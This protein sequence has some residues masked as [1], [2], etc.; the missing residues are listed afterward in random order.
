MPFS[1]L[2]YPLK[3]I[4]QNKLSIK[5]IYS[6]IFVF[7]QWPAKQYQPRPFLT[8]KLISAPPCWKHKREMM[9]CVLVSECLLNGAS[10]SKRTRRSRKS[11]ER[12]PPWIHAEPK[13]VSRGTDG[14]VEAIKLSNTHSRRNFNNFSLPLV[15]I[16]WRTYITPYLEHN[17][18][19]ERWLF[20]RNYFE[21]HC[22]EFKLLHLKTIYG[23]SH[24][25][26]YISLTRFKKSWRINKSMQ[27]TRLF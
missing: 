6:L 18:P 26:N 14:V 15:W 7:P 1:K 13:S 24:L 8:K 27:R 3:K 21:M 5:C 20:L 17:G 25:K 10:D 9:R 4:I 23:S 12:W 16:L 19:D 2:T 11:R 22:M